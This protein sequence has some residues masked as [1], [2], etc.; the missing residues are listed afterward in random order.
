MLAG[1]NRQHSTVQERRGFFCDSLVLVLRVNIFKYFL[2][3]QRHAVVVV[4]FDP[5]SRSKVVLVIWDVNAIFP[6]KLFFFLVKVIPSYLN[7]TKLVFVLAL[8]DFLLSQL[9]DSVE[10][11]G[12]THKVLLFRVFKTFALFEGLLPFPSEVSEL[13]PCCHELLRGKRPLALEVLI[14]WSKLRVYKILDPVKHRE[15]LFMQFKAISDMYSL[16]NISKQVGSKNPREVFVS[17][18]QFI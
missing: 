12:W 2:G 10:R 4:P 1:V 15:L 3:S 17:L 6:H 7:E 11:S 18:R 5:Q 8:R 9:V 14:W 16:E 13:I